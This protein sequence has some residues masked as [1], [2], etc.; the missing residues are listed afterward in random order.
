MSNEPCDDSN[1]QQITKVIIECCPHSKLSGKESTA[2]V[3][4][5]ELYIRHIDRLTSCKSTFNICAANLCSSVLVNTA[6]KDLSTTS[7]STS[8]DNNSSANANNISNNNN[9]SNDKI[10]LQRILN[11]LNETCYNYQENWWSYEVC[12]GKSILQYH[13]NAERSVQV[14]KYILNID[15]NVIY[16]QIY[17]LGQSTLSNLS[18]DNILLYIEQNNI[19]NSPHSIHIPTSGMPLS[20][21]TFNPKKLQKS[22]TL[23]F[24]QGTPC[25]LNLPPQHNNRQHNNNH[26][27]LQHT[28]RSVTVSIFCGRP[29]GVL[30]ILEDRT[31]HYIINVH[32]PVLCEYSEFLP[33]VDKVR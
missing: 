30:D 5:D 32:V 13:V 15:K 19:N 3:A 12:L 22:L 33:Q 29:G 1:N 25:D 16:D 6:N 9:N 10:L 11:V 4:D 8:Q 28:N 7:S 17:Y 27:N 26:H 31:C 23:E 18:I 24:D 2:A 14:S 21:Q 20:K